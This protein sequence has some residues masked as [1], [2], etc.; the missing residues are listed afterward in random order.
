MAITTM[1]G[2]V[3]ALTA[4]QIAPFYKTSATTKGA[5]YYHSLWRIAGAPAA[6][7]LPTSGSGSAVTSATDGAMPLVNAGGSNQLYVGRFS[8]SSGTVGTFML[9][10]RLVQTSGLVGN[11]T[12]SQTVNSTALTRYTTGTGVQIW[13]EWYTTTGTN[14]PTA[15]VSYTNQ[16]GVSGRTATSPAWVASMAVG[17]M[18]PVPLAS[19]DTGVR[20]VQ[21]VTLSASTSAAGDFGIVLL[22]PLFDVPIVTA[23]AGDYMDAFA[24]GLPAVENNAC[25][26]LMM[27]ASATAMN[28]IA[29][30]LNIVEG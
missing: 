7:N 20:S 29:G 9:Y 30:Q 15:T 11:T 17:Q 22:K 13:L 25:L 24:C 4:S 26:A 10:D 3:A 12:G 5:G 21:S 6:A 16:A 23:N 2:L 14:T 8:L 1:N 19:G 18:L 28:P 27:L